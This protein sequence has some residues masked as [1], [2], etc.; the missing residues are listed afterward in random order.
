MS[1][2][3]EDVPLLK[4]LGVNVG[5]AYHSCEGGTQFMQS[6]THTISGELHAKLQSAEF[7]GLFFDG[8]EDITKTEQEVV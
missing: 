1:S 7:W 5:G 8:S 3:S 6:I 2:Y 4:W